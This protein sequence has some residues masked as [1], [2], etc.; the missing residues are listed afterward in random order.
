MK[1]GLDAQTER[2]KQKLKE[3]LKSYTYY[4]KHC[5]AC[6]KYLCRIT[7]T[8]ELICWDCHLLKQRLARREM[9]EEIVRKSRQ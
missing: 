3:K 7:A 5:V 6:G 1:D 4:D 9:I 8:Y 2:M